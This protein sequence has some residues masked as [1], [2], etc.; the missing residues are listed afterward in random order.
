MTM[1]TLVLG[2]ARSGKSHYAQ[3]LAEQAD[4]SVIYI[5]TATAGDDEMRLRIEQH[6]RERPRSW[7]L[8]EEPL[9]LAAVLQ[10]Q[11]QQ[12]ACVLVDCLTLWM[13]N[14]LTE[15]AFNITTVVDELLEAVR[16]FDGELIM[17]SNEVGLGVV[18][19][20][21]LSRQFVDETGR[22]HQ[23]LA[24]ICDRVV[25]TVAGL[26]QILKDKGK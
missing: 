2:G 21:E 6:Q 18:P 8:I 16:Q 19:M 23:Q 15:N 14:Q 22:L 5:A 13:S 24:Q 3:Q 12:Q 11:N 17:V 10:Q 20:G 1:K 9:A 7:Q 25:M 4:K 26:P